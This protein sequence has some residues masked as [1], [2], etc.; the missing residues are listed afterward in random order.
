MGFSNVDV[1][2]AFLGNHAKSFP[3]NFATKKSNHRCVRA[4][5][6]SLLDPQPEVPNRDTVE[7]YIMGIQKTRRGATR[8]RSDRKKSYKVCDLGMLVGE[9]HEARDVLDGENNRGEMSFTTVKGQ[10]FGF[11]RNGHYRLILDRKK[12]KSVVVMP[13]SFGH[14]AATD[15]ELP[16]VLRFVSDAPLLIKELPNVP[17]MDMVL[18][19]FCLSRH[20]PRTKQGIQRVVLDDP[21]CRLVQVDCLGNGGGTVFL[22]LCINQE[23]IQKQG[24]AESGVSFSVQANCRGMSC[25]TENGLP[26]HETIAKG[27]KFEAA[28]RRYTCDFI[29]EKKSRLLLVL[30]QSGQDNE[31]GSIACKRIATPAKLSSK[32]INTLDSF[33]QLDPELTSE[34]YIERGIFNCVDGDSACNSAAI[35]YLGGTQEGFDDEL[36]KALALSRRDMELQQALQLSRQGESGR[37][38]AAQVDVDLRRALELSMVDSAGGNV[39]FVAS[40]ESD[41]SKPVDQDPARMATESKNPAGETSTISYEEELATA[42]QLSM[43]ESNQSTQSKVGVDEMVDL[44]EESVL[45]K[46]R[47]VNDDTAKNDNASDDGKLQ[48]KHVD[49]SEKR[50]LAAE[51]AMKRFSRTET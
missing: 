10:M 51:A 46:R 36:E 43:K 23:E 38:D 15:K 9:N 6:V 11:R 37:H 40:T 12:S 22:Y 39:E 20:A 3:S 29:G 26:H 50:R 4:F 7:V 16:F 14:P 1:V 42:I 48:E 25:R 28:W 45:S 17:R 49:L 35:D 13:I 21:M 18:Q 5:E 27:K 41:S 33:L 44:T 8:G 31:F 32:Q 30:F 47:K 2:L 34:S 19:T 24:L